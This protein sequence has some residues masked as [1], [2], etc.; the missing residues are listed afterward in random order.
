[1]AR[2]VVA[3]EG[4]AVVGQ[5]QG[6]GQRKW[7][8]KKEVEGVEAAAAV[9]GHGIRR[10]KAKTGCDRRIAIGSE[11]TTKARQEGPVER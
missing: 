6:Q 11:D 9:T 7:K 3:E 10:G 8:W 4:V 5:G 1:V 2:G